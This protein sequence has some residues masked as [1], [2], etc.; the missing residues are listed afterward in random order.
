MRQISAPTFKQ[1][2]CFSGRSSGRVLHIWDCY[3][4]SVDVT[5]GCWVGAA[6]NRSGRIN[7]APRVERRNTEEE[8]EEEEETSVCSTS[9]EVKPARP[10]V[11]RIRSRDWREQNPIMPL[12]YWAASQTHT[13][14]NHNKNRRIRSRSCSLCFLTSRP[15]CNKVRRLVRRQQQLTGGQFISEPV[16]STLQT[17]QNCF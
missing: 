7:D 15:D 1:L 3:R 11:T 2:W 4:T 10:D 8:E 6:P 14:N 9:A 13:D 5:L 17:T 16:R 12:W